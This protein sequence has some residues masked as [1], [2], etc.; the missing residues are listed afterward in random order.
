MKYIHFIINPI[1]GNGKHNL[2]RTVLEKYFPAKGFKITVDYSNHKHH[3]EPKH[4]FYT[5]YQVKR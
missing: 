4:K 5:F 1:S 2:T 3:H